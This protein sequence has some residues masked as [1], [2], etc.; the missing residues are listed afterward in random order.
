MGLGVSWFEGTRFGAA[1]KGSN[2]ETTYFGGP[3]FETDPGDVRLRGAEHG[4]GWPV[5]PLPDA[6][7]T[8]RF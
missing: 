1:S 2:Q 7:C 6:N 5:G 4:R 3:C 8:M